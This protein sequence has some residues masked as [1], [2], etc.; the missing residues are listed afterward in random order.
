M[1]QEF[2]QYRAQ[3]STGS[4]KFEPRDCIDSALFD[5]DVDILTQGAILEQSY[6]AY[7]DNGA[8]HE[9]NS[10]YDIADDDSNDL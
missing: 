1:T 6:N 4:I 3:A 5:N 8:G 2:V 10:D 9:L 7:L